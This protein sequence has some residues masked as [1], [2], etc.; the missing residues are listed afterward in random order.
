MSW[1]KTKTLLVSVIERLSLTISYVFFEAIQGTGNQIELVVIDF[2]RLRIELQKLL[3][4]VEGAR[5]P[6]PI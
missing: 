6:E 5:A 3:L 1:S 2:V 4:E